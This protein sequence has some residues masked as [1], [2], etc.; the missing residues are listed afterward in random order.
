M[1]PHAK[2]GWLVTVF[3]LAADA[4][5]ACPACGDKIGFGSGMSFDR[6]VRKGPPGHL[7]LLA[8]PDSKLADPKGVRAALEREGHEIHVVGT[9]DE[10]A[11][12]AADGHAD[13]IV[14]HWKDAAPAEQRLAEMPAP[15]ADSK[16]TAQGDSAAST[17]TAVPAPPIVL[18]VAFESSDAA[19]AKEHGADRCL[20]RA[21]QRR[22][23]KLLESI[24]KL[25][26]QRRKG[27]P[28]ECVL[29]VAKSTD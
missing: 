27:V 10:L 16:G 6:V 12:V 14:T 19:A 28:S 23:R 9:I 3:L 2:L 5:Y 26:E 1:N 17:L 8:V 20:E 4:A 13:L 21:D 25:L 11:K 22:G 24:D 15:S 7:V 18:P 29:A